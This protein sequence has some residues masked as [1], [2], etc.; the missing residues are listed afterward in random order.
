[1]SIFNNSIY[2]K[3]VSLMEEIAMRIEEWKLAKIS[4]SWYNKNTI[5]CF[6]KKEE[7]VLCEKSS[8]VFCF[9]FCCC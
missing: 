3:R 8:H 1:M 2:P 4:L 6:R 9:L 7:K 5:I